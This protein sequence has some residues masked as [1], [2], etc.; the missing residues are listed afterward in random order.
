[1]GIC[2]NAPE[3]FLGLV[4]GAQAQKVVELAQ[5]EQFALHLLVLALHGLRGLL[6]WAQLVDALGF[7]LGTA[8]T[9][10]PAAITL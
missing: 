4:L 7:L 9:D 3:D 10:G 8:G 1:M 6:V 5:I 2:S